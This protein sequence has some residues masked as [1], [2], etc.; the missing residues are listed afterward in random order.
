[1]AS[2]SKTLFGERCPFVSQTNSFSSSRL[3]VIKGSSLIRGLIWLVALCLHNTLIIIHKYLGT[4]QSIYLTQLLYSPYSSGRVWNTEQLNQLWL[5]PG[6][7]ELVFDRITLKITGKRSGYLLHF[8]IPYRN[9]GQWDQ[10]LTGVCFHNFILD[11][12]QLPSR[13]L[14]ALGLVESFT[15][16]IKNA[17]RNG[18][19][20]EKTKCA[21]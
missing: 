3:E 18:E 11:L 19:N 5:K 15:G 17:Q 20:H 12:R 21:S 4:I 7:V 1:M 14:T 6:L 16:L 13:T 2:R 9:V 8:S 10:I